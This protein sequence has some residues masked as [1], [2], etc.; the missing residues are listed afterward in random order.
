MIRNAKRL[1]LSMALALALSIALASSASA[2]FDM[3][4]ESPKPIVTASALTEQVIE[5]GESKVTC[6]KVT[7]DKT[8]IFGGFIEGRPTYSEC[9][10]SKGGMNYV[11]HIETAGCIYIF[12][13]D[14]K[15]EMSCETGKDILVKVTV[16][17]MS[18]NCLTIPA[19][20][21]GKPTADYTNEGAGTTRDIRVKSTVQ[22]IE[23]TWLGVCG[24]GTFKDGKY[25]GEITLKGENAEGKSVGIWWTEH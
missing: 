1:C 7:A 8:E 12:H 13:T 24:E 4:T 23:Y 2:W 19:Q 21:P 16:L 10:A 5:A 6:K 18:V 9:T 3:E 14:P 22:E 15:L 17:G 25:T 11:A 20:V